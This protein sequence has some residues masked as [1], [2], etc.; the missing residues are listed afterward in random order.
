[1]EHEIIVI[2]GMMAVHDKQ[3]A[4]QERE[5]GTVENAMADFWRGALWQ[6]TR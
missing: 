4:W 3:D 2:E 1:M 6:D 5:L